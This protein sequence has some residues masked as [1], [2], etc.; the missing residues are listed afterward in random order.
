M[1]PE[2]QKIVDDLRAHVIQEFDR[3]VELVQEEAV[4]DILARLSPTTKP[5][6]RI[7]TPI[8]PTVPQETDEE[9]QSSP[10]VH[11]ANPADDPNYGALGSDAQPTGRHGSV[12]TTVTAKKGI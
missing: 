5:K 6:A 4:N 2:A 11:Y 9:P 10:I 1:S 8:A 12:T 7:K 3:L